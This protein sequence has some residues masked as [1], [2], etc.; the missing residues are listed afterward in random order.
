MSPNLLSS[1]I[2]TIVLIVVVIILGRKV[3][4]LDPAKPFKGPIFLVVSGVGMLN[5]FIKEFYGEHWRKFTPLLTGIL[6]YLAFANTASLVGLHTPLSN[7]NIALSFSLLAFFIIQVSGLWVRTP[8]KRIKDLMSPS[9]LLLPV[10]LVSE[11][12]TPLAM[13]LRLFGNLL[14]GAVITVLFYSLL[15][16]AVSVLPIVVIAHPIF[17]IGFGLIQAFVYFMLLTIFLSM[18]IESQEVEQ[19][20][21]TK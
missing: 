8:K 16:A 11:I 20:S 10:N 19:R 18:A 17:N 15:P 7:I 1:L 21:I 4:R 6:L 9:P 3:E 14:S 5:D 13:G 12:S 2:V